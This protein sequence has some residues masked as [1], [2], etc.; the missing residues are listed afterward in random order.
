MLCYSTSHNTSL[1]LF[2]DNGQN[3]WRVA[4][5]WVDADAVEAHHGFGFEDN[6]DRSY[7]TVSDSSKMQP[8]G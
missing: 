3:Q 5:E 1:G 4:V 2:Q 6:W 8:G 7:P